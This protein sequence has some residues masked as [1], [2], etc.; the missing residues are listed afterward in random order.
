[1][2]PMV[3]R[4]KAAADPRPLALSYIE[5]IAQQLFQG[6]HYRAGRLAI[7]CQRR[8]EAL[9]GRWLDMAGMPPGWRPVAAGLDSSDNA[10]YGSKAGDPWTGY[11]TMGIFR[12]MS[13]GPRMSG[14]SGLPPT[15][16]SARGPT[17]HFASGLRR[18]QFSGF[19]ERGP[20]AP[21]S[22]EDMG[23]LR[24]LKTALHVKSLKQ[25]TLFA[26]SRLNLSRI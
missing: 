3:P 22:C 11:Q 14:G 7:S 8:R 21:I 20:T 6:R 10:G 15:S 13:P 2:N 26:S 23:I 4:S 17:A 1:M 19:Q 16:L 18:G 24:A 5:S 25:P 12:A 9:Q